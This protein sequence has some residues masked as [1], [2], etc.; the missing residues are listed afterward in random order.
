[1]PGWTGLIPSWNIC[2]RTA[3]ILGASLGGIFRTTTVTSI[4]RGRPITHTG[5]A[6][7]C[8]SVARKW[9]WQ[10]DIIVSRADTHCGANLLLVGSRQ[11]IGDHSAKAE[12]GS[13]YAGSVDTEAARHF[14][15]NVIE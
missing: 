5:G 2:C 8:N 12:T 4:P 3:V 15:Q 11:R 7:P 9:V 13:K 1:M 14:L 6:H 10:P